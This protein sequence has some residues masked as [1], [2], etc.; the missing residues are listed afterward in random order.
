M[1][2]MMTKEVTATT[3]KITRMENENGQPKAV[4]MEDVVLLGNVSL[5]KAQKEVSKSHG[6]GVIVF[7]VQPETKVYEMPVDEFI[8][9]ASLK[10]EQTEAELQEVPQA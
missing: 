10:Q 9:V 2:R 4:P 6:T 8:K 7:G 3:V 1:R 5:E